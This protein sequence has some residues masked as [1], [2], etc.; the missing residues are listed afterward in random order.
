MPN[1]KKD[2][3]II[4]ASE[5]PRRKYLL[6][7]AG[8][9]FTVVPSRFDEGSVEPTTPKQTVTMLADAKA[10]EVSARYPSSWV[11]GADTIVCI[12]GRILG[13]P[14]S[15]QKACEML[16]RL[17]GRTHQVFTGYSIVCGS[18]NR[19]FSDTVTTDVVFKDLTEDEI[20]WYIR[21]NEPFDKAGAYAIQGL[22]TF[23]VRRINGSYTNVVG[24]PVCEV[25][26]YLIKEKV[27]GLNLS[28][29]AQQPVVI[30]GD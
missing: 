19:H 15:E 16:R 4:L 30:N 3:L 25:I 9:T 8:L 26:E 14:A 1:Q 12:D 29:T 6:E 22:G 7:Q 24:L 18:K 13:K 5:S 10:A 28:N 20:Q 23:L 27:I 17:S 11:I 21:T 2:P